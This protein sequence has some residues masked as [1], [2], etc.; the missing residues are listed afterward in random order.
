MSSQLHVL[1]GTEGLKEIVL[2][3][4]SKD[5]NAMSRF[6][7]DQIQGQ[8]QGHIQGQIQCQIQ[9]QIPIKHK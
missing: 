8:T 3:S 9:G 2:D 1:S 7:R 5:G 6:F 4:F